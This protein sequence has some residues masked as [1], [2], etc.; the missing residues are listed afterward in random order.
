MNNGHCVYMH[1]IWLESK[2]QTTFEQY[3]MGICIMCNQPERILYASFQ[4]F[5]IHLKKVKPLFET[6]D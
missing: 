2:R 6:K 3:L 4:E 5:D 1:V